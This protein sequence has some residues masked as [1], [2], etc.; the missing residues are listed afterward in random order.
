MHIRH[1]GRC[2][3]EARFDLRFLLL[4]LVHPR[5][6]DRLV[7]TVFDSRQNAFDTSLDLFQSTAVPLGLG[8]ALV[9]PPIGLLGTSP[10]C[11][12]HR[13]GRDELVGEA[14]QHTPLDSVS[15]HR[16]AVVADPLPKVAEAAIAV[17]DDDAI[18]PTAAAAGEQARQE[19]GGTTQT[20]HPHRTSCMDP[21]GCGVELLREFGLAELHPLP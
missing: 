12:G 1:I 6:H 14:A 17:I 10:D 2:F 13:L 8:A 18:L 16:T 19:V 7:H 15:P 9:V 20:I 5:L 11:T 21:V 3:D 4:Q